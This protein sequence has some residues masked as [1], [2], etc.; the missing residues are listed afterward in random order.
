MESPTT[1]SRYK[2]FIRQ[3]P[4]Y[5]ETKTID[6]LRENDFPNLNGDETYLDFTGGSLESKSQLTDHYNL[7]CSNLLGN[8]HSES[9]A[10]ERSTVLI[11]EA[12][13]NVLRFFN[14]SP[15]EYTVIFTNNATGALKLVGESYPFGP[16]N[17]YIRLM[18]AHNSV[19]GIREFAKKRGAKVEIVRCPAI[20]DLCLNHEDYTTKLTDGRPGLL[21][22]TGQSNYSGVQHPLDNIPEAQRLGW[23]VV[24]DAAALAPTNPIDLSKNSADAMVGSFYKMF[25][26]PT[27]VGYLVIK[28]E[29]LEKLQ[30]PWFSGGTIQAVSAQLDWHAMAKGGTA[31]EDGT[32]NYKSIPAVTIGLDYLNRIGMDTI[33]TRVKALTGWL[34]KNLVEMKHS[35]GTPM[36]EIQGPKN[37]IDRGGTIAFNVIGR[38]GEMIDERHILRAAALGRISLRTGC[39][40]NPGAGEEAYGLDLSALKNN[41]QNMGFSSVDDYLQ[42]LGLTN[43]GAV[44]V[45]TGHISNFRDT[46]M[47]I[48]FIQETYT[49]KQPNTSD[50]PPRAGC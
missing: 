13:A 17:D 8:P 30:R 43:A 41:L 11:E 44:R 3:F 26:Y 37:T 50:M 15:N 42:K 6:T 10:S 39:F 32:V 4:E 46:E 5:L 29:M 45:S 31:F 21:A 24:L 34:L 48:N 23:D 38:D 1:S 27:G 14:A 22:Y 19:V 9:P 20:N 49:N 47:L 40:C 25:G 7:L 28:N 16:N 35:N 18:D 33:H 2:E 36:I 12:R